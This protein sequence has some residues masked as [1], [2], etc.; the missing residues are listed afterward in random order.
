MYLSK[1]P[2]NSLINVLSNILGPAIGRYP[3]TASLKITASNSYSLLF[4]FYAIK[5]ILYSKSG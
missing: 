3:L 5:G 4:E 1:F 2:P